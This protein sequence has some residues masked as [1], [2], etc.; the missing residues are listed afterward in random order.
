MARFYLGLPPKWF[1]KSLKEVEF[2]LARISIWANNVNIGKINATGTAT[3]AANSATT[4]LNDVR[5]GGESVLVFMPT[6]SNAAAG[7]T[8]L[9]VTGRGDKTCT[10]NHANNAQ[11]DRTY[12]YIVIG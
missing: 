2:A 3:L 11:T 6:T 8:A 9:F 12:D 10:L 4:T 1:L 5:I 7:M